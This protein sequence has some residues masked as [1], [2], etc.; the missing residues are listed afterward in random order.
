MFVNGN[1]VGGVV[2]ADTKKGL[3]VYMPKPYRVARGK[4]Y[5]YTRKLRGTVTVT[6]A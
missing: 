6:P 3:V 1:I 4:D 2:Y 5:V